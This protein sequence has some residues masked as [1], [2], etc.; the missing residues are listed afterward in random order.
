MNTRQ[1]QLYGGIREVLAVAATLLLS[2]GIGTDSLWTDVTGGIL[3]VVSLVWAW[4]AHSGWDVL[5]SFIRKA[6]TAMGALCIYKGWMTPEKIGLYIGLAMA[7]LSLIWS[8]RSKSSDS[9]PPATP[10][11]A[12]GFLFLLLPSCAGL[13]VM[14][15]TPYGK[16]KLN[17]D[18]TVTVTPKAKPI[19]IPIH[20]E[21]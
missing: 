14:A 5:E 19:V 15:R 2:Y 10:L 9:G 13:T 6:L 12:I 18:G 7:L 8:I 1:Q 20:A 16:A 4:Q 21:K 3:A 17:P 11:I